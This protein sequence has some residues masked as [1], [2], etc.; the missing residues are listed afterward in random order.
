MVGVYIFTPSIQGRGRL[1]SEI[2]DSQG[3]T[4]IPCFK[5]TKQNR[6]MEESF[7]GHHEIWHV[8]KSFYLKS[9]E[10]PLS[11]KWEP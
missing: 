7:Q 10:E 2:Q 5:K 9:T 4:E 8:I 6:I 3:F 11:Y 1:I